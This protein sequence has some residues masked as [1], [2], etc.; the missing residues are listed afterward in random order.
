MNFIQLTQQAATQS[1]GNDGIEKVLY[2][3]DQNLASQVILSLSQTLN[4]L[5]SNVQQTSSAGTTISIA[6]ARHVFPYPCRRCT[7]AE[8]LRLRS[9][10]LQYGSFKQRQPN[11]ISSPSLL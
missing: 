5:S 3:G 4:S 8:Y 10:G 9:H 11:H 2:G 7:G 6:D 1:R